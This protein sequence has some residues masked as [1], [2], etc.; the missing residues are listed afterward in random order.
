VLCSPIVVVRTGAKALHSPL[1][2]N[3]PDWRTGT[4]I[5]PKKPRL[6]ST[7]GGCSLLKSGFPIKSGPVLVREP[8]PDLGTPPPTPPRLGPSF[9]QFIVALIRRQVVNHKF[10]LEVLRREYTHLDHGVERESYPCHG[11]LGPVREWPTTCAGPPK[12]KWVKPLLTSPTID[13]RPF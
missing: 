10:F 4:N 1:C 6:H 8:G 13:V 7:A 5:C 9:L 3:P 12:A 11:W 2:A